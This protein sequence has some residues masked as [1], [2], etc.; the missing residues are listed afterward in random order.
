MRVQTE[1]WRKFVP[2]VRMYK[3]KKTLFYNGCPLL[4]YNGFPLVYSKEER[5]TWEVVI[6]LPGVEVVPAFTFRECIKLES[7]I[8]ND[9]VKRLEEGCFYKCLLLVYISFSRNLQFIERFAF[10]RCY[11]LTSIDIPSTCG[12]VDVLAFDGCD[13]LIIN[14]ESKLETANKHSTNETLDKDIDIIYI[15]DSDT[16]SKQKDSVRDE[17]DS[18]SESKRR[19]TNHNQDVDIRGD[20]SKEFIHPMNS[21]VT[22]RIV[23]DRCNVL[24][25]GEGLT[26]RKKLKERI[27]EHDAEIQTLKSNQ[28]K[29][30][31]NEYK[32]V[33]KKKDEVI[34]TL[35]SN[36]ISNEEQLREKQ[37]EFEAVI[38]KKDEV[39]TMLLSNKRSYQEQLQEKRENPA[40]QSSNINEMRSDF[41]SAESLVDQ[42]LKEK[43]KEYNYL[44]AM[45]DDKL[46]ALV[47]E[48]HKLNEMLGLKEA[49]LSQ[50]DTQK[51]ERIEEM[52]QAADLFKKES[53]LEIE[54]LNN[55]LLDLK[56]KL[57]HRQN[58]IESMSKFQQELKSE[59]ECSICLHTFEN[60]YMI[61]ECCHRFCKHCIEESL[62]LNKKECPL[63]RC[64]VTSK[65]V[66]RKDE[67]IGKI[68]EVFI[69]NDAS[70]DQ[71]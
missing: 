17:E 32:A 71:S 8:M 28:Y 62:A 24:N 12:E 3:G 69:C 50:L 37:D 59:L 52:E 23:L 66:L 19:K 33:I 35:M 30:L 44:I 64:N 40:A 46:T 21:I 20:S 42:E 56:Q 22:N 53:K 45:M 14:D 65:R 16:E 29:L 10:Y 6:L 41:A 11:S 55:H 51:E 60:P 34:T 38:Q 9:D 1:E 25:D 5:E 70:S 48:K 15:D 18:S 39:I 54:T 57:N 43:E 13:Q 67:L 36:K 4:D 7:V 2:G 31:E 68:S 49:E 27:K 58:D 47:D 26:M 61:P 63:C